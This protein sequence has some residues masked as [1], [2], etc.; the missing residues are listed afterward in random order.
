M[1]PPLFLSFPLPLLD[2]CGRV[3]P[4]Q[5]DLGGL[6]TGTMRV[7]KEPTFLFER[8]DA[9]RKGRK[10][11]ATTNPR[12]VGE[13]VDVGRL[14]PYAAMAN[15][16]P[17]ALLD[18][19]GGNKQEDVQKKPVTGAM[20]TNGCVSKTEETK[21]RI[22]GVEKTRYDRGRKKKHIEHVEDKDEPHAAN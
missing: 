17:F 2:W 6:E 4:T 18:E 19:D 13:V 16:N 12:R 15:A 21:E 5:S 11:V 3:D 9:M 22:G 10:V 8:K 14:R 20:Q 1:C 7:G